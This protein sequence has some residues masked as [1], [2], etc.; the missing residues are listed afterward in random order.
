[1]AFVG[2]VDDSLVED[3]CWTGLLGLLVEH[4]QCSD[5][6]PVGILPEAAHARP[7]AAHDLLAGLGIPSTGAGLA[8]PV[9]RPVQPRVGAVL[10]GEGGLRRSELVVASAVDLD[11]EHGAGGVTQADE[12]GKLASVLGDAWPVGDQGAALELGNLAALVDDEAAVLCVGQV[13]VPPRWARLVAR[14]VGSIH[15]HVGEAPLM[16]LGDESLERSR[17]LLVEIAPWG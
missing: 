3:R 6:R 8:G 5:E 1:M 13:E 10:L 12:S 17:E 16:G 7:H 2:R 4:L 9:D 14:L 15:R 11:G